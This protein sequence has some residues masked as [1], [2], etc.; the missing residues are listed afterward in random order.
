VKGAAAVALACG[1]WLIAAPFVFAYPDASYVGTANGMAA[2]AVLAA[3]AAARLG[4]LD[5]D[6]IDVG[7]I[8]AYCGLWLTLS[9][10]VLRYAAPLRPWHNHVIVGCVVL[11]AGVVETWSGLND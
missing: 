3:C 7:W 4:A 9:P 1:V 5:L 6:G 2:G 11:A 8:E 10:H